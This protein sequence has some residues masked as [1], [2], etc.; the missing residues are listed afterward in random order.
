MSDIHLMLGLIYGRY[1][2]QYDRAEHYLAQA[3][4]RLG[5]QR[6]AAMA[7]AELDAVRH[8]RSM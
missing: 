3:A 8:K 6:K 7:Q 1:L 4:A 5:D 2:H